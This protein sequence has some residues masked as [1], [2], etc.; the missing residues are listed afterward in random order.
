MGKRGVKIGPKKLIFGPFFS[1][2]FKNFQ[3]NLLFARVV[4]LV[5]VSAILDH[6]WGSKDPNTSQKGVLDVESVRKTFKTLNLTTAIAILIKFT[7]IMYLHESV[8][9]NPLRAR[10]P[11]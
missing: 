8:D 2:S 5:R 3:T 10:N 4:L 6:I 1:V 9:R 11:V 7:M